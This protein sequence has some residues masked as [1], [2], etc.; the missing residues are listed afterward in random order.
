MQSIKSLAS[1]IFFNVESAK[2]GI[3]IRPCSLGGKIHGKCRGQSSW[4][5]PPRIVS[6][7]C[8]VDGVARDGLGSANRTAYIHH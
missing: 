8:C 4:L 3:H 1:R 2:Y 7:G 6:R 5:Y